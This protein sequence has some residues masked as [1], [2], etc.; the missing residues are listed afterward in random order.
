MYLWAKRTKPHC[1]PTGILT[2]VI[3]PYCE[4]ASFRSSSLTSGSSPPTNTFSSKNIL[5]K[6]CT[7]T[8][9]L[10]NMYGQNLLTVVLA[11]SISD[12]EPVA[13]APSGPRPPKCIH[14]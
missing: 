7:N 11:E 5:L 3:S 10:Y 1:F 2:E 13:D 6:G 8:C 9:Y 12:W 14:S 4:K